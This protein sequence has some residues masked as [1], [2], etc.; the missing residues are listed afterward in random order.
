MIMAAW[1][2]RLLTRIGRSQA[3]LSIDPDSVS[4]IDRGRVN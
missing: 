4:F 3:E 1:N 2:G